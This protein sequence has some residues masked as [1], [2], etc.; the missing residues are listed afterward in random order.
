MEDIT[1]ARSIASRGTEFVLVYWDL[2][3]GHHY[4]RGRLLLLVRAK[5]VAYVSISSTYHT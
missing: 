3:R 1:L 5:T 4:R 2:L